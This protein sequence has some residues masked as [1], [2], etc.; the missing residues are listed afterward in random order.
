MIISTTILATVFVAF[1]LYNLRNFL[2]KPVVQCLDI[3]IDET[4]ILFISDLHIPKSLKIR[5]K[6]SI[7]GEFMKK[8]NLRLLFIIGDLFD[9]FHVKASLSEI[10]EKIRKIVD[11]LDLPSNVT[12]YVIFSNSSHD[13]I[14]GNKK[15][16]ITCGR[17]R[18]IVTNNLIRLTIGNMKIY[19][20]HGD[21]G[22]KNGALAY[23]LN[24]IAWFLGYPYLIERFTKRYILRVEDRDWLI[25]G[26]TH[27]P[28]ISDEFKVANTGSWKQYW[29][30]SS[31]TAILY[32]KGR[33]SLINL[34]QRS[35]NEYESAMEK[36]S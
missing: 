25:M 18:I 30:D 23:L 12:M 29:R 31:S 26:H 28:F 17:R 19:L 6:F 9:D 3:K 34:K 32:D 1:M 22:V 13:P 2:I 10:E 21:L 33:L 11:I 15:I 8:N 4:K 5:D 35:T 16:S 24:K 20:L 27:I 7:I 14:I 36:T